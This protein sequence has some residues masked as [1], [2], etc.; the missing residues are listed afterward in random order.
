[1]AVKQISV[2]LQNRSG[3]LADITD[4]LSK[5]NVNISALSISESSDFGVLRLIVDD[6]F[7]AGN[8]LKENGHIYSLTDVIAVAGEDKPGSIA[9]IVSVLAQAG[10]SLDYAYAFFAKSQERAIMIIKVEDRAA[11]KK[12]L[13]DNGIPLVNEEEIAK[14]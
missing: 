3:G 1:M 12:V 13:K 9:K 8:A 2:F 14:L 4:V 6:V 10:M 7:A 11:A 5:A